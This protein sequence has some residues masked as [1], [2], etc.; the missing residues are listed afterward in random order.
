[1]ASP[2][3]PTPPQEALQDW[4]VAVVVSCG[5]T[6]PLFWVLVCEKF[7]LC[8]PWLESLFPPVLWK[9]Y[10]KIT[11]VLKARFPGDSQ[12]L[13]HIPRLLS[14][15]WCSKPSQQ[16]KNFDL[17]ILQSMGHL[18]SEYGIW[19]YHDFTPPT[20]S[21]W[22]LLCLWM[23]GIFFFLVGSGLLL[24]IVVQQ[25]V[26]VLVVSQEMSA[27]SSTP[28][29]WTSLNGSYLLQARNVTVLLAVLHINCFIILIILYGHTP[30]NHLA[31]IKMCS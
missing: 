1:M 5:V 10:N 8:P 27:L 24:S 31:C 22:V 14:L 26:A 13:C 21:L 7:C 16:C 15:T 18:P 12:S 9:S 29:S 11:L 23:W 20:V 6:A 19:F 4:Q 3:Q 2:C 30:H 17:T 25:L 28:P